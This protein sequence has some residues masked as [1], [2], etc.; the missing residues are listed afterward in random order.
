MGA[1][2]SAILDFGTTPATNASVVV[3]GVGAILAGSLVE[4][5]IKYEASADHTGDEHLVEP[6]RLV[7]GTIVV[8]TSFVVYGFCDLGYTTGKFNFAWVWN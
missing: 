3:S 7:A 8:G 2:G 4:A 6:I 5:W 1:Q